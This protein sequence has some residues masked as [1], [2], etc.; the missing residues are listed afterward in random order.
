MSEPQIDQTEPLVSGSTCGSFRSTKCLA[1]ESTPW[2]L[3]GPNACE[4]DRTRSRR[5]QV[6]P[7]D[8]VM[9]EGRA[10][11][12]RARLQCTPRPPNSALN[13]A[14]FVY[15]VESPSAPDLYHGR[16]EGSLLADAL[17][18]DQIP[19]VSRTAINNEAL[20]A[21]LRIGLPEAMKRFPGRY[22]I[23]HL[24]AHGGKP[25]I[26]LSSGEVI[27]WRDL[28]QLLVPIN[29]SLQG[30]LLLCMS[31]CEGY[32]ACQMVMEEG[33]APHPYF[34]MV[35]NPGKPTWSDTAVSYL[36]FYHLLAKGKTIHECAIGMCAASGD[37]G[38]IVETAEQTKRGYI[39]FLKSK[40][41]PAAAQQELEA[42]AEQ[43]DVPAEAKT[44]ERADGG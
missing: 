30:M 43:E 6:H 16:S 29:Q 15:I 11:G 42:V 35:G 2:G 27:T 5:A 9:P 4:D 10:C 19:S 44:L 26:Q 18:L 20:I 21:T 14:I 12:P 3:V 8:P 17:R 34:A 39:E 28:R 40:V 41:A 22:P 24:S 36:S 1:E 13:P 23:L 33:E 38:W 32:S 25:G 7:G 31:A 37:D